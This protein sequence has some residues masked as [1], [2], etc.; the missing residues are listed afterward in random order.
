M[1]QGKMGNILKMMRFTLWIQ[2]LS[3]YFLDPYLLATL[4]NNG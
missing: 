1:I 2:G 4:P 3:F